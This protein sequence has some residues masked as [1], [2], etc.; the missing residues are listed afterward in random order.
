MQSLSKPDVTFEIA[1]DLNI[2]IFSSIV[3]S[4]I[5]NNFVT[6][7]ALIVFFFKLVIK[8]KVLQESSTVS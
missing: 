2:I 3:R 1:S 7:P 8:K 6:F 4:L 5:L